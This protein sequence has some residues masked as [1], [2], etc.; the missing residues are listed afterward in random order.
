MKR[1]LLFPAL[2]TLACLGS[3]SAARAAT[4]EVT[5]TTN[6][7]DKTWNW[8]DPATWVGSPA[9]YPSASNDEVLFPSYSPV[10]TLHLDLEETSI[11]A[12]RTTGESVGS[13]SHR[14]Y[15]AASQ[16]A[17]L[18]IGTL[19][20]TGQSLSI[21]NG[22]DGG[23]LSV[24]VSQ[25]IIDSG[26]SIDVGSDTVGSLAAFNV[27]DASTI[28]GTFNFNGIA[29]RTPGLNRILLGA[30]ELN[31]SLYVGARG[32]TDAFLEISSL[33]GSGT[34]NLTTN[35]HKPDEGVSVGTLVIDS[36]NA[37][38]ANYEGSI[39]L[40]IP[41]P[42]GFAF[43]VV[44]KGSGTQIFSRSTGNT[45]N[46]GTIIE[47]GILA[48]STT[49]TGIGVSGLGYGTVEVRDGGTL[50]GNGRI[51]LNAG[52]STVVES[53][54][55]IAPSAH[56]ASGFA[57]LTFSSYA[58]P[59]GAILTLEEGATFRFRLGPDNGSDLVAFIN[60][61]DGG[62]ALPSGDLTLRFENAQ[63]GTFT[64]FSFNSIEGSELE[65]LS[66][67]LLFDAESFQGVFGHDALTIFV[68]VTAIP[69][70][71]TV[72]LVMIGLS[73]IGAS[74]WAKSRKS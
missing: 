36:S 70:P 16:A 71:A 12:F 17:A 54:G 34:L 41:D 64:L 2:F 20:I 52:E 21:A 5:V 66:Q 8:T 22:G 63:E 15:A 43:S 4:Y 3:V 19:E 45:Y 18:T 9:S 27:N 68:E 37:A 40:G 56:L 69:E 60:Y 38:P 47:E 29:G 14:L 39:S 53:G 73:A 61:H 67:S 24:T 23:T 46:G 11:G 1:T 32:N 25:L 49:S 42:G 44:K 48:I 57:A 65:A 72:A 26:S 51:R 55:V 31:G 10:R 30:L 74:Q 59:A 13:N 35:S 28:D 6:P 62:L 33:T 58:Q 7:T 50:A